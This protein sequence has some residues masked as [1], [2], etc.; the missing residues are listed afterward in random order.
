MYPFLLCGLLF[1]V[2]FD[3]SAKYLWAPRKSA[4]A[5]PAY[6]THEDMQNL[7]S[8][9]NASR[10]N[11]KPEKLDQTYANFS[12]DA[13]PKPPRVKHADQH[14]T[15]MVMN[16][17]N[18]SGRSLQYSGA[19]ENGYMT[20]RPG[21]N[22][23]SG[24]RTRRRTIS[25]GVDS[26]LGDSRPPSAMS[27]RSQEGDSGIGSRPASAMSQRYSETQGS[28]HYACT[29]LFSD[30]SEQSRS[31]STEVLY[32]GK[33][34]SEQV[35]VKTVRGRQDSSSNAYENVFSG[36]SN[37]AYQN[38]GKGQRAD[39]MHVYQSVM[40]GKV[41]DTRHYANHMGKNPKDGLW[42]RKTLPDL[43]SVDLLQA[44]KDVLRS[45]IAGL[46]TRLSVTQ[47]KHPNST[48]GNSLM[49]GHIA[50]LNTCFSELAEAVQRIEQGNTSVVDDG[51][52]ALVTQTW[53]FKLKQDAAVLSGKIGDLKQLAPLTT[54]KTPVPSTLQKYIDILNQAHRA[55]ERVLHCLEE[56]KNTQQWAHCRSKEDNTWISK[57]GTCYEQLQSATSAL[58]SAKQNLSQGHNI[59]IDDFLQSMQAFGGFFNTLQHDAQDRIENKQFWQTHGWIKQLQGCEIYLGALQ[60]ARKEKDEDIKMHKKNG[61]L[62]G[63]L[64]HLLKTKTVYLSALQKETQGLENTSDWAHRLQQQANEN[65]LKYQTTYAKID[66]Y[67]T[68][69]LAKTKKERV[70]ETQR[71][72][73]LGCGGGR[74]KRRDGKPATH[75]TTQLPL[76]PFPVKT[77]DARPSNK[78][79]THGRGS[80][81]RRDGSGGSTKIVAYGMV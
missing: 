12:P 36:G 17:C 52:V 51:N 66:K 58:H 5:N 15:Y 55:L 38:L 80:D 76:I 31:S 44:L 47:K 48:N 8:Q 32:D 69:A 71:R 24:S 42:K 7:K 1:G 79:K 67:A 2:L 53:L 60:E 39:N 40:Y 21:A 61:A 20:M 11:Q 72:L 33:E 10:D 70:E 41:S 3:A 62:F 46:Q 26:G 35:G 16:G 25:E 63:L 54:H 37:G 34:A 74:D 27:R 50:Q 57:L 43:P 49:Q 6:I 45:Q 9:Q 19:A 77:F 56:C 78:P 18:L 81:Q 23:L 64:E 65:V 28:G 59:Q 30:L 4:S 14:N 68:Q 29:D 13:P 75:G 73:G 22:A